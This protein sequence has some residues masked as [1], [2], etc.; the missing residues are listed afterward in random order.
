MPQ[1]R[2]GKRNI[3]QPS[4]FFTP[5]ILLHPLSPPSWPL[6]LRHHPP[7]FPPLIPWISSLI[8]TPM[9]MPNT[10]LM[11]ASRVNTKNMPVSDSKTMN[12]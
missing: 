2:K 6:G 5:F 4:D 1:K 3:S 12:K 10:T 8:T 9:L 11:N 7:L